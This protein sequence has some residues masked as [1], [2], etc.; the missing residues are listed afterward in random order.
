MSIS[1]QA[2]DLIVSCHIL[3][4]LIVLVLVRSDAPERHPVPPLLRK[5]FKY[6]IRSFGMN[7]LRRP[8]VQ[9]Q[10]GSKL[11]TK[12]VL[13]AFEILELKIRCGAADL[14]YGIHCGR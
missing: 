7:A 6:L 3:D 11:I 8:E 13:I 14:G 2:L 12:C 1:Q 4:Q 10:D 9:D 5:L